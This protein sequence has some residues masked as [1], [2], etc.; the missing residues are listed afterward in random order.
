MNPNKQAKTFVNNGFPNHIIDSRIKSFQTKINNNNNTEYI[1]DNNN[2]NQF[3]RNQ[4]HWNCKE[5]E[6]AVKNI[7]K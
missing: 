3:S 5:D 1:N 2:I 4:M 7:I 6:Y